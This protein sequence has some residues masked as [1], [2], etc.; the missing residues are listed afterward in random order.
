M[1][2]VIFLISSNQKIYIYKRNIKEYVFFLIG[3]EVKEEVKDA[4]A[5][6]PE[7][8]DVPQENDDEPSYDEDDEQ[9]EDED[10]ND[11][12]GTDV[13]YIVFCI[14]QAKSVDWS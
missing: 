1:S 7:V 6:E 2:F 12:S 5:N 9:L 10:E 14:L 11:E 3:E 4:V 8:E 13:K